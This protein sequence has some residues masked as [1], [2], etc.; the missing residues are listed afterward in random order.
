[1]TRVRIFNLNL[2]HIQ[3]DQFLLGSK[4]DLLDPPEL[5]AKKVRK[6]E[7]VPKVVEGNGVLALI[8][9]VLLPGSGLR[10]GKREFIIERER[11]GLEPLVY[12]DIKQIQEDYRNDIVSSLN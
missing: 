4:I 5:V 1:M 6:A 7:C 12:T 11:D 10:N 9:F 2:I 8:E 3:T